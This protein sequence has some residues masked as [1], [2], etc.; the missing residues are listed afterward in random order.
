MPIML[1]NVGKQCDLEQYIIFWYNHLSCKCVIMGVYLLVMEG[2]KKKKGSRV[3]E[4][5]SQSNDCGKVSCVVYGSFVSW[6]PYI[7]LLFFI[8]LN[9][10]VFRLEFFCNLLCFIF[11]FLIFESTCSC[12]IIGYWPSAVRV[13]GFWYPPVEWQFSCARCAEISS[14]ISLRK[15]N[16]EDVLCTSHVKLKSFLDSSAEQPIFISLSSV[17]RRVSM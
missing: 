13:C 5:T 1:S 15:L 12:T 8:I 3:N 2:K 7:M 14:L 9:Y 11:I 10:K 6:Y 16:A 17:G 4:E